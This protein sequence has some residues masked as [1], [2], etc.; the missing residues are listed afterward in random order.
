MKM[1]HI[2]LDVYPKSEVEDFYIKLLGMKL[3]K[4]FTISSSL[5]QTIFG[6]EEETEVMVVE[7][8]GLKLELFTRS[9]P[10]KKSFQ[11]ICLEVVNREDLL[12]HCQSENYSVT[13]VEKPPHDLIFIRDKNHNLFELFEK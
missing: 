2:G 6:F 7:K 3:V 11:H 8:D 1:N 9:R 13:K 10:V 12:K 4:Q 5:T